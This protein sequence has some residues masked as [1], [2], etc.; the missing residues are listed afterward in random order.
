MTRIIAQAAPSA[1]LRP[2]LAGLIIALGL[3][4]AQAARAQEVIQ[5]H[6]ISTFGNLN[7]PA[8][9][10]HLPYV[11]PNA[12]KGGEIS[13]AAL[14]TFD[15]INPYSI[16]GN[17]AGIGW[18][19]YESVLS[20]TGDEIGAA[21]C[22]L[23][24]TMEYPADRSWVIFNLRDDVT[25]SDGSPMTADDV[26]FSYELFRDKGIAEFRTVAN[27][28]FKSV[29]VLD[30]HRIKFTFAD[31][32]A[33]RDLPAMAGGLT[34]F[35]KAHYTANKRDLEES[36]LEPFLGTGPYVLD[37]LRPGQQ[38]ILKRNPE[39]WGNS[40]PL[41]IGRNNF[42]RIRVEYFS[43]TN[44]AFEG[45]KSGLFT[46]HNESS[47]KQ[48]ATAYD[49]ENLTKGAVI[50]A[51][52]PNGAIA[53]TQS[54]IFNLRREKFQDIR[55]RQAIGLMFNF[56]WSNKTLFYDL[57]ERIPSFFANTP[58]Q[59]QGAPT[60]EEVALLQPL[61]DQGL[62]DASILTD[63][64]VAPPTS[65][66]G[67]NM[68]RKNLRAASAL[69]DAAGWAA[70]PDGMRVNAKGEK[71]KVE[72]LN[73]S[74]AF[75]RIIAPYVENLR[76]LGVDAV[77]NTI[78]PAQFSQRTDPPSFDFDIIT[79]N[80]VNG[81]EP[82]AEMKQGYA[83][84]IRDNSTRNRMGL[85]DPAVDR[86][87]DAIE[88]AK[89]RADLDVAARTLDRVL[90]RIH[91]NVPQ[92]YKDVHTVAYYD[93]YGY[94]EKLPPYDLGHLSFWWYDAAKGEALKSGGVLK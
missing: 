48:W 90:R 8:D 4:M 74:P 7:L 24:T 79:A 5:A 18:A 49:F 69:L 32:A 92:W 23:C 78:D 43:D 91:F 61:V 80:P 6:G 10:A 3:G 93:Q 47:S 28:K 12:P 63:D 38:I 14:G 65:G 21:Y 88:A 34:I 39:Y 53:S 67:A 41:Q 60:P 19:F 17:A 35:S 25:F 9:F 11:N 33:Y 58:M 55:V 50:K 76:A 54:F 82:G 57:Y 42:D 62:L 87:L 81:Y 73:A 59:A 51:E 85:A 83:S 86:L 84:A 94:P 2:A 64:A 13:I 77:L 15:S 16:K 30:P 45:F 29:Q 68:D 37:S 31:G 36:S 71:L 44:A 56:A 26:L 52:L 46:F 20:G 22:L 27:E 89:T 66:E 72:F 70:G 75:E 40:H 1:A